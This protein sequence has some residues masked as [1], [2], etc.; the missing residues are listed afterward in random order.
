MS[1]GLDDYISKPVDLHKLSQILKK[2]TAISVQTATEQAVRDLQNPPITEN[3]VDISVLSN[4][5]GDDSAIHE[6]ILRSF[7][8]NSPQ[9]VNDL[10]KAYA[11]HCAA[12]IVW[13]THK[14]KSCAK[15]IGAKQLA[16]SC[17]ALES[18][19]REDNWQDITLVH[20]ELEPLFAAVIDFIRR[21]KPQR[22]GITE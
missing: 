17:Q 1:A 20:N 11:N 14:L 3:I 10:H 6:K 4:I 16:Q 21:Y 18:A 9:I 5:L 2:H 19:A 15:A 12:D 22:N 7:S 13:S 8:D